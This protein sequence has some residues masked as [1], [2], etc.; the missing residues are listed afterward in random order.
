MTFSPPAPAGIDGDGADPKSALL[1]DIYHRLRTI[2]S[3]LPPPFESSAMSH[4]AITL[5]Q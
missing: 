1:R 5:T 2:V 3:L 4:T